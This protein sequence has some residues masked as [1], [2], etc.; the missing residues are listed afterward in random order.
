MDRA[1]GGVAVDGYH[2]R[3]SLGARESLP[4]VGVGIVVGLAGFYL[5]RLLIQRTPLVRQRDIPVV[6]DRGSVVRVPP[7]R[8][9]RS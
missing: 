2:Y 6:G 9:T 7:A 3:R 1:E 5:A 4:A 8:V